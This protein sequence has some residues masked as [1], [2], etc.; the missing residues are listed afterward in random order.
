MR[1]RPYVCRFVPATHSQQGE[2]TLKD[3]QLF[4]DPFE[5][6]IMPWRA[7]VAAIEVCAVTAHFAALIAISMSVAAGCWHSGAR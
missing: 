2:V 3:K 5:Q 4:E 7:M 6:G 1:L